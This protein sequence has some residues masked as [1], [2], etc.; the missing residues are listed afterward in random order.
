MTI[1]IEEAQASLGDIVDNLKP[2]DEVLIVRGQE[3]VERRGF[4]TVR[5]SGQETAKKVHEISRCSCGE[6]VL[7]VGDDV[8]DAAARQI[9]ANGHTL[10]I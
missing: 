10:G 5:T 2:G 9:E 6:P 8:C 1:T 4:R 7:A 3:L